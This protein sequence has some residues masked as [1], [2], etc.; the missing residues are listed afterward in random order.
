MKI[1]KWIYWIATILL[2]IQMAAT[3]VGDIMQAEPIVHSITSIGFPIYV[4]PFFGVLKILG[5]LTI[6]F[7]D[8]IHLKVGAYAGFFFYGVGAV[9][10]H[11]AHS[12]AF[13]LAL[14]AFFILLLVLSS[15]FSWLKK[16]SSPKIALT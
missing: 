6:L 13:A 14:P 5:V 4:L 1:N 12:D 8:K 10:S 9:Y 7:V 11:L 2:S 3:G 16:T 15:Y